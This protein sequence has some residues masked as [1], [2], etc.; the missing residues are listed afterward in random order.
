MQRLCIYCGSSPGG[1]PEFAERA[2]ALATALTER[3]IDVVYGGACKGIM[4]V[5]ADAVLARGGRVVG[6]MPRALVDKEVAHQGLS[7]LHV[8]DTMHE[9]KALMARLADGFVALPGG[10]G[11]LE[12][13]VEALTWAQLG[14][15]EK[16]CGLFNV[17][18]YYDALL[19]FFANA[20]EDGFVKAAHRKM[21]IVEDEPTALLDRFASYRAPVEGKWHE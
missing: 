9:R 1:R 17:A 20:S 7:E 5:V 13:I 4:G 6:V 2:Q 8:T 14:F 3:E 10:F 19:Q 18:G 21:L 16:P 11:T 15:H 12:E